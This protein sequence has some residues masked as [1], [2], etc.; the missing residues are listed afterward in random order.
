MWQERFEEMQVKV[1][2][3]LV[4]YKQDFYVDKESILEAPEATY[5]WMLRKTGTQLV[6]L[7]EIKN[8]KSK[9]TETSLY[10]FYKIGVPCQV[11]LVSKDK[12]K[13]LARL[14]M[15]RYLKD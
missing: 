7:D 1:D 3:F 13:C 14:N 2:K 9:M 10:H 15:E 6:N 11:Y 4:A 12:F 8:G 5:L